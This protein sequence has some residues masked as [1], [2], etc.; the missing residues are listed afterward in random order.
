MDVVDGADIE[1]LLLVDLL[2][3]GG[4]EDDG[5]VARDGNVLKSPADFIAVH[6]GH[7]HVEQNEIRLLGRGGDCQRLLAVGGNFRPI[8]SFSNPE[9]TATLVGV[10]STIKTSFLSWL[11]I[12]CLR[13]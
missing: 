12:I 10:S 11:D 4:E 2:G 1:A 9:T 8:E 3:L 6:A 13:G 7:H 5:N